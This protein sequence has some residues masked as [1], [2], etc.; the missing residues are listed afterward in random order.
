MFESQVL[1]TETRPS[2]SPKLKEGTNT[3]KS[4]FK[5]SFSDVTWLEILEHRP[6]RGEHVAPSRRTHGSSDTAN[7]AVELDCGEQGGG[8]SHLGGGLVLGSQL[9]SRGRG[10]PRE[11]SAARRGS[12]AAGNFW[13]K[14]RR[15]NVAPSAQRFPETLALEQRCVPSQPYSNTGGHGAGLP[16]AFRGRRL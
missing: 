10:H 4:S 11:S 7:E 13:R 3:V 8:P 9:M 5:A 1:P 12:E 16:E 6:S 2:H 14:S 15:D